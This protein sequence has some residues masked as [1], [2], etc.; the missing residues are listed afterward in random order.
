MKITH[1]IVASLTF[2]LCLLARAAEST[3]IAYP[4]SE[5]ASFIIE[6][7]SDWEMTPAEES[8]DFFHLDG[9][10]GALFSFRTIKGS[11]DALQGAIESTMGHINR[12]FS[13]VEMS[14][15]KDWTPGGLEGFYAT[16]FGKD[17]KGQ[18]VQIGVAWCVLNDGKIAQMWFVT[19]AEDAKGI[20]AAEAIANS[21]KSPK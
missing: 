12:L 21:L 2:A 17:K 5:A 9:P 13:G 7:P 20:R 11:D 1:V 4:T 8:G 14:D 18:E 15:A 19:D 6:V 3:R 16:G 10:T